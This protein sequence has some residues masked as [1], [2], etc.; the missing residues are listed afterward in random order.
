VTVR[1]VVNATRDDATVAARVRLAARFLPRL[2]G[3]LGRS[4][5]APDEGLYLTPCA[6]IHTLFMAFP[7]D[8]AFLDAAG[9]VLRVEAAIPPWRIPRPEPGAR[10]VLEL[11]AGRLAATGT[12]AGDRLV[13]REPDGER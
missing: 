12:T 11:A 4:G 5:L 7:I 9:T 10:G 3:L 1:V 2:R 6:A 13:F 8:C